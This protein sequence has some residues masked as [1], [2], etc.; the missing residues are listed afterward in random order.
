MAFVAQLLSSWFRVTCSGWTKNPILSWWLPWLV[1]G[2]EP[3]CFRS[4]RAG[5]HHHRFN[6]WG[7]TMGLWCQQQFSFITLPPVTN[8]AQAFPLLEELFLF[9]WIPKCS[10]E[11]MLWLIK[12]M[13]SSSPENSFFVL[14]WEE[15]SKKIFLL[16]IF[17]WSALETKPWGHTSKFLVLSL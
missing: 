8:Y 4:Y 15:T 10:Q 11:K 6:D 16:S 3:L 5:V 9:Q 12:P 2:H 13:Q 7:K 14:L 1:S 17:L